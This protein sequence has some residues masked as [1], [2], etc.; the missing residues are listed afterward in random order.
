MNEAQFHEALNRLHYVLE[1]HPMLSGLLTGEHQYLLR[2]I[3]ELVLEEKV[4]WREGWSR[5]FWEP[6]EPKYELE[7]CE[8]EDFDEEEE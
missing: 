1:I 4:S 8:I 2:Q 3:A 7:I 6:G 5:N